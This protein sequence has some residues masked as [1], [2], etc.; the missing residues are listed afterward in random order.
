MRAGI[1]GG[2]DTPEALLRAGEALRER[3]YRRLEAFTPY[4][5]HGIDRALGLQRSPLTW[6]VFP[7][8]LVGAGGSYLVQW[9]C[10]AYDYR[11]D[12]GGRP[13]H[14]PLAF[15]PISFETT[16]LVSSL[17]GFV[18]FLGLSRLP[19]LWSP[20]SSQRLGGPPR[21]VRIGIDARSGAHPGFAERSKDL[22]AA[23]SPVGKR[24]VRPGGPAS[25]RA[26]ASASRRA[27]RAPP[28]AA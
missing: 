17:V 4:P 20:G 16:V 22:G 7:F 1:I 25:P 13:P 15:V 9:F 6:I 19:E 5:L 11:L 8:A 14:S 21:Q 10:N 23:P 28:I 27:S 24:R 18:G 2:F 26:R 3:G 12:V